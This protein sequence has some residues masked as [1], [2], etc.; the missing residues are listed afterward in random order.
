MD[1]GRFL[2]ETHRSTGRPSRS[3]RVTMG[4]GE[5]ALQL[6]ADIVENR[7]SP[8]STLPHRP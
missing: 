4:N 8:L 1:K 3:R 2:I 6:A 5:L 7:V